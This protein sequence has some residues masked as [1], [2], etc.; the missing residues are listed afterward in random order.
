MRD[1]VWCVT[2]QDLIQQRAFSQMK[3]ETETNATRSQ[4]GTNMKLNA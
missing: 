3:E 2:G 4:A 1:L